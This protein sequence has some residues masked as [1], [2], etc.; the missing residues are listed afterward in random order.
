MVRNLRTQILRNEELVEKTMGKIT[1]DDKIVLEIA[2]GD[3]NKYVFVVNYEKN[4]TVLTPTRTLKTGESVYRLEI[5]THLGRVSERNFVYTKYPQNGLRILER[6]GFNI[7]VTEVSVI[8][9]FGELFIAEQETQYEEI[10]RE[11]GKISVPN[12]KWSALDSLLNEDLQERRL[13]IEPGLLRRPGFVPPRKKLIVPEL[14]ENQGFVLWYNRA[15][16]S[17]CV[18]TQQGQA[19]IWWP[20]TPKDENGM[21]SLSEGQLIAFSRLKELNRTDTNFRLEIIGETRLVD[22]SEV[23]T[24]TVP[25]VLV[26][27]PEKSTGAT[28]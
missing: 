19:R 26:N 21:R 24:K 9:Q 4:I 12:L 20:N 3:K 6:R 17:G 13:K 28:A 11:N 16:G 27:S 14:G 18:A 2:L 8:S 15:M 5:E 22:F 25:P 23:K 10:A 7:L 1:M